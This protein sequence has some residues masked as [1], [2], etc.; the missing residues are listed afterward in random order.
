MMKETAGNDTKL[1][2][3]LHRGYWDKLIRKLVNEEKAKKLNML[4]KRRS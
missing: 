1:K 2:N 3:F 4:N